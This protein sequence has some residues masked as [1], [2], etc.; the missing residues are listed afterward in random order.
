MT[1]R[2]YPFTVLA[3]CATLA[4]VRPAAVPASPRPLPAFPSP[5]VTAAGDGTR[6]IFIDDAFGPGPVAEWDDLRTFGFEVSTPAAGSFGIDARYDSLT[7]R[8]DAPAGASR[9][10]TLTLLLGG[11]LPRLT[12]GQ[13]FAEVTLEAG[14]MLAGNLGGMTLQKGFHGNI[15]IERPF[16]VIYDDY[17]SLVLAGSLEA[18]LGWEQGVWKL[19]LAAS[20]EG[21]AGVGARGGAGLVAQ[22]G[23]GPGS[24]RAT[25]RAQGNG[26]RGVSPT[27][28]QV[29]AHDSGL[30]VGL[31]AGAGRLRTSMTYNISSGI[32]G[33]SW[34]LSFGRGTDASFALPF[35]I[36]LG[37]RVDTLSP[38]QRILFPLSDPR[39]RFYVSQESGWQTRPDAGGTCTRFSDFGTGVEGRLFAALGWLEVEAAVSAGPY[40]TA[41]SVQSA[42]EQR[43]SATSTALAAGVRL[44]PVL[45][46]GVIEDRWAGAAGY[47]GVGSAGYRG[48]ESAGYRGAESAGYR[49]AESA[50]YRGVLKSGIGAA[51]SLDAPLLD[52]SNAGRGQW[53]S[54]EVFFF[55]ETR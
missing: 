2:L 37:S 3:L 17:G 22:A 43:S 27:L 25:L 10:D 6:V 47:R 20:G 42:T 8:A 18:Q 33:G 38:G 54:L 34:G 49:G 5:S 15:G 1:I 19:A 13:G 50:G 9:I 40:L 4:P 39:I 23:S 11:P 12:F 48:A 7:W 24:L 32:S 26:T 14:A 16:P 52:P 36:E 55:S 21:E 45:R 44:A 28:D 35:A 51:L 46:I 31:D 29:A 30:V 41:V 53:A